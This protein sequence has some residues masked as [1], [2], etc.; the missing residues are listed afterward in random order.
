MGGKDAEGGVGLEGRVDAE[1]TSRDR[2]WE[3]RVRKMGYLGLEI[4]WIGSR[5]LR[6][7]AEWGKRA[8]FLVEPL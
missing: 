6:I 4:G 5:M 8:F 2:E 7:E 3:W 1:G